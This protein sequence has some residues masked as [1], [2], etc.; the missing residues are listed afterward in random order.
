MNKRNAKNYVYVCP[1]CFNKVD[2]C[3][4]LVLPWELIQ[5][6]KKIW[7]SIKI[8]NSKWYHTEMCCEGHIQ[9]TQRPFMYI[10]FKKNYKFKS[11]PEGFENLK[12]SIRANITGKSEDAKKRKQRIL[13]KALYDWACE[14]ESSR[15]EIL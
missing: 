9:D 12:G 8:L 11:V 4:C 7:P 15:S 14:L 13:L 2:E 1:H 5:I 10:M 3:K 6:D